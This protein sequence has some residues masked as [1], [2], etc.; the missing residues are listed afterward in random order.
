VLPLENLSGDP[1]QEYFADGMTEALTTELAQIGSI[2]VI[3]QS[4][5]MQFK[6]GQQPASE[7]ARK[8]GVDAVVRASVRRVGERVRIAARLIEAGTDSILWTNSYERDLRDI[9]A[10][11]RDV[12][13]AIASEIQI[14]LTPE[15]KTRLSS[16]R[17]VDPEAY[18]LFLRAEQETSW[19]NESIERAMTYLEQ[20]I[21]KDPEYAGSRAALASAYMASAVWGLRSPAE[22]L[23]AARTSVMR[24]IELDPTLAQAHATLG[25]LMW[26][27][28]WDFP[29]A[30][31]EILR[32]IA[33]NSN[34]MGAH[35]DFAYYLSIVGRFEDAI[36]EQLRVEELAPAS[37]DTMQES[38][39]IYYL[40]GRHV[41]A[42][43]R[44]KKANELGP[45]SAVRLAE[46][47]GSFARRGMYA[48][49]IATAE[50]A[51]KLV[52]PG[53]EQMADAY[54]ADPYSRCGRQAEA[55]KWVEIWERLSKQ[56]HVESFLMALMNAGAGNRDRAFEWLEIAFKERSCNMPFLK[57][58]PILEPLRSDPR[59]Q[60]LVQRVGLPP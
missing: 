23:P 5:V 33:L 18:D 57:I 42:I 10:L 27:F 51:R 17:R 55:R 13:G 32:A 22:I 1:Q 15:Q 43:D 24:A 59:F 21:Q 7:I 49:S 8:L 41:E 38:A 45:T 44:V 2:R 58:H 47:A 11:Q 48:E 35:G 20:S 40:A 3:D 34:S 46:M 28:D 53:K 14:K 56:R 6:G 50:Q 60:A 26:R 39:F 16:T 29:V 9:L 25:T 36:H 54:L 30:E 12:A 19:S 31:K 37:S 4:S 52:E